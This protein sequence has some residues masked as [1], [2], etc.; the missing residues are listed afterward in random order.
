MN[1]PM[2]GNRVLCDILRRMSRLYPVLFMLLVS[3]LVQ[4]DDSNWHITADEWARPRTGEMLT[5]LPGVKQ[6][7]HA[8]VENSDAVLQIRYPGGDEGILWASELMA[9]L[10]ALGVGA[11]RMETLPGSS[12][13]DAI[14]LL[15]TTQ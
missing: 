11:E 15:V 12:R 5:E 8:L 1:W 6:A 13:P 10:T 9:W 7:V 2:I 3:S 4:A 14:Q